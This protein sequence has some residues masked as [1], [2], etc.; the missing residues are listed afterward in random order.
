[1]KGNLQQQ[2]QIKILPVLSANE[3]L[4]SRKAD[5]DE[6][7]RTVKGVL[8]QHVDGNIDGNDNALGKKPDHGRHGPYEGSLD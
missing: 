8:P 7:V 4:R 5:I 3:R 1:M 6:V 2:P